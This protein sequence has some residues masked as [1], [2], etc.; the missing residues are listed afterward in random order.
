MKIILNATAHALSI[1]NKTVSQRMD[2][3]MYLCDHSTDLEVNYTDAE[4]EKATIAFHPIDETLMHIRY[5]L[6]GLIHDKKDYVTDMGF[7]A[8]IEDEFP[9]YFTVVSMDKG[10]DAKAVKKWLANNVG[11]FTNLQF[12]DFLYLESRVAV[13]HFPECMTVTMLN[14]G[15]MSMT[16]VFGFKR[17]L[18]EVASKLEGELLERIRYEGWDVL[19]ITDEEYTKARKLMEG[20]PYPTMSTLAL[21]R[22]CIRLAHNSGNIMLMY[23]TLNDNILTVVMRDEELK[24]EPIEFHIELKELPDGENGALHLHTK[25]VD[26]NVEKFGA[27]ASAPIYDGCKDTNGQGLAGIF[28]DAN[29]FLLNFGK[30][31]MSVREIDCKKPSGKKNYK[32]TPS[33]RTTARLY[34]CYTLKKNWEVKVERKKAE[35]RCLAWG[36]RGHWR[37]YRSGK[38][39]FVNAYIKGKEKDKY[40][41]K[42]YMLFPDKKEG[43]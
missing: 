27:W 16:P 33:E 18:A 2:E 4:G 1:I 17:K 42:D 15:N 14:N 41:G 34:K 38:T 32:Y 3:Y 9:N 28:F 19:R 24:R 25:I 6:H 43:A 13:C 30:T 26:C 8:R 29:R 7:T 12:L 35:F 11:E 20:V 23:Y 39:V 22:L 37:H 5:H 21:E 40:K 36:V 10:A 31:S